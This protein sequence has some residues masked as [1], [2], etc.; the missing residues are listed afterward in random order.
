MS[1]NVSR[2]KKR[3]VTVNVRINVFSPA[4]LVGSVVGC[5]HY[6]LGV[7]CI[8]KAT[9]YL[10]GLSCRDVMSFPHPPQEVIV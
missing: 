3:L 8:K 7:F 6:C 2:G 4:C 1:R 5:I 10:F 9:L